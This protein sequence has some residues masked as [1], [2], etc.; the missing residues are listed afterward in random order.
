MDMHHDSAS[1]AVKPLSDGC[2]DAALPLLS[3]PIVQVPAMQVKQV[4]RSWRQTERCALLQVTKYKY[5]NVSTV[6]DARVHTNYVI[7]T[8]ELPELHTHEEYMDVSISACTL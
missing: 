2:G 4:Q 5:M 1:R 6:T 8:G 3:Q 7:Q